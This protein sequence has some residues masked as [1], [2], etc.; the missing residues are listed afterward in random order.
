[1]QALDPGQLQPVR[2]EAPDPRGML[3]LVGAQARFH[4]VAGRVPLGE[5]LR[6]AGVVS[7]RDLRAA[8]RLRPRREAPLGQ[9]L[10]AHGLITPDDLIQ[11]LA[12]QW[13]VR[14]AALDQRPPDPALLDRLDPARCLRAGLVPWRRLG[15]VTLIA[16][17][18]PDRFDA[19]RRWL[20]PALGPVAMTVATDA[21]ITNA[22]HAA[23]APRLVAAA[24][25][26]CPEPLS[27]RPMGAWRW[28]LALGSGVALLAGLSYLAPLTMFMAGFALALSLACLAQ[29]LKLAATCAALRRRDLRTPPR[30][31]GAPSASRRSATLLHPPPKGAA[32]PVSLGLTPGQMLPAVSM[33]VPLYHEHVI[34]GR[35]LHRLQ[36]QRYPLELLEICL[37]VEAGDT[38]TRATLARTRLPR[39]ARLV[40]VPPGALKTKPRAMNFALDHC[41]GSVIG[42]W[43]AE[44]APEPDQVMKAVRAFAAHPAQVG[45]LQ[46]VLDIYNSRSTWLSRCFAVDYAIWFRLVLPGIARLGLAVPLGGTT[47]F[48]R[49]TALEAVGGWDAHNVTEDA[50]LGLRLRRGGYRTE[51]FATVTQEEATTAIWPWIRQRSRWIKG[52]AMTWAVHMRAP[53][54]LWRGLGPVAFFGVQLMF[55]GAV[56]QSLVAPLLWSAW[57]IPLGLPHPLTDMVAA[58]PLAAGLIAT[59]LGLCGALNIMCG[60]LAVSRPQRR[61]LRAWV[62]A[63]MLYYPLAT[64]AAWKALAELIWRP[65]FW[66][67]TSHGVVNRRLCKTSAP[68]CDADLAGTAL[69]HTELRS[70][71]TRDTAPPKLTG[72]AASECRRL[73]KVIANPPMASERLARAVTRSV[74]LHLIVLENV[75]FPARPP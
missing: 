22:L 39:N 60:V 32:P 35:L 23:A 46:G 58:H 57:A 66:D 53:G 13:Q 72:V 20:E 27:C 7:D 41:R 24:E 30:R 9:I 26:R 12:R 25:T 38:L 56:I 44:D 33:L 73:R 34:A 3:R 36:T 54:R 48:F 16:T 14:V 65:F 17:A 2:I 10:L 74:P 42:I 69:T 45:C 75:L 15:G 52:Y 28:R 19:A 71:V 49:R 8:L 61:H 40:V 43:D 11:Q 51:M 4:P 31:H 55:A 5:L 29:M 68:L 63:L 67:K 64:V 37:I 21:A 1:M 59:G 70:P 62:P 6:D 18:H 50:D 47:V